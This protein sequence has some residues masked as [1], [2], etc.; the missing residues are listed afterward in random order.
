MKETLYCIYRVYTLKVTRFP[1]TFFVLLSFEGN[2]EVLLP[3]RLWGRFLTN[4]RQG[5]RSFC[6]Y[7]CGLT[8]PPV[9]SVLTS[10][11]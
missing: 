3:N 6:Y 9:Q 11:G 2:D 1:V 10:R 4:C 8:H 7:H 5:Q